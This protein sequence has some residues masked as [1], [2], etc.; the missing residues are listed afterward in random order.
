MKKIQEKHEKYE[1]YIDHTLIDYDNSY[2]MDSK[3]NINGKR[4]VYQ[5]IV[6]FDGTIYELL[7]QSTS[8][9]GIFNVT[10]IEKGMTQKQIKNLATNAILY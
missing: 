5:F 2:R 4:L 3:P 9:N 7:N 1:G 8:T 10:I 6:M